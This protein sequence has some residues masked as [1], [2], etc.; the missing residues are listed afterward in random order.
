MLSE[1]GAILLDQDSK[2]RDPDPA[3]RHL[4]WFCLC[5]TVVLG[6]SSF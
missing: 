6:F 5:K 4:L 1:R 2:E 3:H